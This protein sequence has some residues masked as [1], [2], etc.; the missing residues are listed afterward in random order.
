MSERPLQHEHPA[1]SPQ[2]PVDERLAKGFRTPSSVKPYVLRMKSLSGRDFGGFDGAVQYCN[3]RRE[4]YRI[5]GKKGIDGMRQTLPLIKRSGRQ[6][7]ISSIRLRVEEIDDDRAYAARSREQLLQLIDRLQVEVARTVPLASLPKKSKGAL[8]RVVAT[9]TGKDFDSEVHA[10]L[11][12]G[13]DRGPGR[14]ARVTAADCGAGVKRDP[15]LPTIC[16]RDPHSSR[17]R[18]TRFDG[19]CPTRNSGD[20]RFVGNTPARDALR[21]GSRVS[22]MDASSPRNA[23]WHF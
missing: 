20:D 18:T 22:I 10:K 21:C 8:N 5:L 23:S 17:G 13:L 9:T 14:R 15:R 7:S 4:M 1:Q 19:T 11:F 16:S 3:C 12:N 6:K 2:G